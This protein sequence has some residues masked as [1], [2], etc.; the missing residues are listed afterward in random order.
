[1][2]PRHAER[3]LN[4]FTCPTTDD[5]TGICIICKQDISGHDSEY[6]CLPH[7]YKKHT[8]PLMR[9]PVVVEKEM[10]DNYRIRTDSGST[11]A[12][13]SIKA[14]AA[15][16]ARA[17]NAHEKLLAVLSEIRKLCDTQIALNPSMKTVLPEIRAKADRIVG[18]IYR[19]KAIAQAEGK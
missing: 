11:V 1:M 12:I 8:T 10:A 13:C 9:L 17:V 19:A 5:L 6:R 14:N 7:T 2:N 4:E 15:Y 18:E 16:I 3:P